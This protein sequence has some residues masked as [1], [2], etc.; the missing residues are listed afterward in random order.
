MYFTDWIDDLIMCHVYFN[1]SV[2]LLE[3]KKTEKVIKQYT[4]TAL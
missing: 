4:Q 1:L 2:V 3:T